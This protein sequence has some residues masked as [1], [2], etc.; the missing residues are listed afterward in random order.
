MHHN[1]LGYSGTDGNAVW[2][3][4]N[5]FYDNS[6]GFS[7]DVFTAPGHPGLPA[8]LRPARAQQLLRNNFNS[9]L[10]QC[11]AGQKP[12][13]N[14]PNQGCS[15]V[16]PTEPVPVGTGMWIAGGNANV[17]RN[18]RFYD[19]WRRGVMLFAVPDAF[20]C[21]DPDNQVAGCNPILARPRPRPPPTATS[22]STTRWDRRRT[23]APQ[24]NGV[25]FW[26][27]Q[28]G[29]IV[30]TDSWLHERQ[31]LVQQHRL[32]RH[33]RKRHRPPVS[34]AGLRPDNLPSSCENSPLPGAH[35]RTGDRGA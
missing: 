23:G 11:A 35:A 2:L 16:V 22:S 8:G 30:D 13:P 33:R 34:R 5:N 17:V 15:D 21:D 9:Y 3:H 32:Q 20:V 10:P 26:W 24:P 28:G 6:M 18:N 29:I 31:L 7:T 4:D 1:L 19:N 12:G 25:D 27:D 14:G